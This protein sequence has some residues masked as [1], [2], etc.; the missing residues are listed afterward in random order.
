MFVEFNSLPD[1]SRV[2]VYQ[3]ARKFTEAEENT[4]SKVLHSFT[5][6][7]VAHGQPLKSSFK[8]LYNQFIVLAADESFNQASGCSIDDSVH[9]I[10]EIDQHFKLDLFNRALVAFLK[11]ETVEAIP[12]NELA[13]SLAK[14]IWNQG[15]MVFNNIVNTKADL[16]QCWIL[17]ANQTWLKRYL[18]KLAV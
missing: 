17:P 4:I 13:N 7:W 3:S 10:K 6:Q 18:T 1:S 16:S 12:M 9:A 11:E 5:Q 14:G 8:I 2:W 15:S